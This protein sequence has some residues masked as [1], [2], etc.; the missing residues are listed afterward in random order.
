M[1]TY[2]QILL[3]ALRIS[4]LL[5]L[6]NV[7]V[8]ILLRAIIG[9]LELFGDLLLVETPLLFFLAGIVDFGSSLSFAQFRKMISG[10]ER[11]FRPEL[12]KEAERRA[13]IFVVSGAILFM[14][15]VLLA[16]VV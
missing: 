9:P 15:M 3:R 1:L 11:E 6:V 12:R 4:G 10:S 7:L 8:V 16:I 2:T 14:I 13:L 5:I